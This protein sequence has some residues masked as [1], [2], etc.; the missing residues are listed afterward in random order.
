MHLSSVFKYLLWI[1]IKH[2][3]TELQAM[4]LTNNSLKI[5]LETNRKITCRTAN[6]K[7]VRLH[8][9]MFDLI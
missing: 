9:L 7:P 2:K 4:Q 6:E 3:A 5:K 1:F 8:N